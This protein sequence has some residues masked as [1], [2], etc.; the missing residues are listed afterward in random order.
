MKFTLAFVMLIFVS[1][2]AEAAPVQRLFEDVKL[3][4]Q[5]VIEHQLWTGPAAGNTTLSLS[6]VAGPTSAAAAVV[7][8]FSAQPDFARNLVM[9]TAGTS[10]DLNACVVTVSG[11]NINSHSISET[12]SF[13]LHTLAAVTGNKAFKSISSV[14]FPASC[15]GGSF[16]V[17]WSLGTGVKMGLKRCMT[18]AGDVIKDLLDG[19]TATVGTYTNSASAV[20]SN[21]NIFNTTPN[22]SHNYDSYFIQDYQCF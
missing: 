8:S 4:T 16:G 11:V 9:T 14:S 17:T 15:E 22:A 12:F 13:S 19:G 6:N 20:E 2:V 3:P 21:T 18:N 5:K 10:N 7:S 1:V